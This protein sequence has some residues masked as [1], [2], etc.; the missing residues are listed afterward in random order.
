MAVVARQLRSE[1]PPRRGVALRISRRV[2]RL[3]V[4]SQFF[5]RPRELQARLQSRR[6][7]VARPAR[8]AVLVGRRSLELLELK[9]CR[10]GTSGRFR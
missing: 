3:G 6:Q 1:T 2:F 4:K 9:G 5:V 7:V 8:W 10:R